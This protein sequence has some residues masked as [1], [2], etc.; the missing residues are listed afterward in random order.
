MSDPLQEGTPPSGSV[1]VW[2][3]PVAST[4]AQRVGAQATDERLGGLDETGVQVAEG[5]EG[6]L[7][8]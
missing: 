7:L 5:D 8:S 4:V 1:V 3:C 2:T 6:S